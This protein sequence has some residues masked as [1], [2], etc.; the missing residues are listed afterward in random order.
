MKKIK[1]TQGKYALV[2]DADFKWLNQWKWSLNSSG[3]S[4]FYAAR[5]LNGKGIKMHRVIMNAPREKQVDHINGN[6]LNNQR[7][8]LRL[9][10]KLENSK[11]RR[12]NINNTSGYKGIIWYK[13]YNKWNVQIS[14]NGKRKNLGYFIKIKDAIKIYKNASNKYFGKFARINYI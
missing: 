5:S 9:C 8:N 13:K 2:D 6:G 7:K 4:L 1:L 12:I 3:R 11:N 14:I 10:T